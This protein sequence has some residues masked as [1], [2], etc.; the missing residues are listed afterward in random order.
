MVA[1]AEGQGAEVNQDIAQLLKLIRFDLKLL[2]DQEANGVQVTACD[3]TFR[4]D[5]QISQPGGLKLV[6]FLRYDG[7]WFLDGNGVA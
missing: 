7:K 4:C 3:G 6:R 2:G 5:V 1:E